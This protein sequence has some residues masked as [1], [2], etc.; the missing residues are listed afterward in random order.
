MARS[1]VCRSALIVAYLVALFAFPFRASAEWSAIAET[2]V[3][4]TDNVFELSSSRRLALAEDPSQPAVVPVKK[5]S[6]V[7]WEPSID[8]RHRS[9]PTNLGETEFSVKAA[10][11][12]FTD[13]P[14]FN[15]GNYRI[16]L[17]QGLDADTSILIRYR[18]VP[19]LFLGPNTERRTGLRLPEEERE[20]EAERL[21]AEAV[22]VAF[23]VARAPLV[24]WRLVRL[25]EDLHVLIQV[26][27]HFVHDGW[28]YALLL[29]ELKELYAA[30]A[31]GRPSPLPEPPVQ[32]A[33]FAVWQRA[34]RSGGARWRDTRLR[35]RSPPTGRGRRAPR[36][37]APW[38]RSASRRSST[39]PCAGSAAA[40]DGRCT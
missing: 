3:L 33:D 16:Q 27:H 6:D 37:V 4:Y 9:R 31:D 7:V 39:R 20:A 35:S 22:G 8:L 17:K 11:F 10:G 2:K 40:R 25:R 38:R 34:S 32:Y 13:N 24:R 18:F 14:I 30:F 19:N 36:S 5:A 29:R 28:S 1:P 12:V 23:D 15:H 21:V 26:E